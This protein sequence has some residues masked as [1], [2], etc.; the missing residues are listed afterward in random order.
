MENQV[1]VRTVQDY[2]KEFILA[3]LKDHKS[4]EDIRKDLVDAAFEEMHGLMCFR[5]KV[6]DLRL[7]QPTPENKRKVENVTK[8][9]FKKWCRLCGMCDLYLETVGIIKPDDLSWENLDASSEA[10]YN[11]DDMGDDGFPLPDEPD[12]DN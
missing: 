3:G 10:D 1:V 6:D 11:E 5:L 9:M 8:E 12:G 2:W 7:A 4:K